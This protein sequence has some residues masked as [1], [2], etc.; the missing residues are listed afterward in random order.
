MSVEVHKEGQVSFMVG[1]AMDG[2]PAWEKAKLMLGNKYIKPFRLLKTVR[3]S[4]GRGKYYGHPKKGGGAFFDFF[5]KFYP[6]FF[7]RS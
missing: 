3:L 4:K 6:V 7:L 5:L 2:A 1:D